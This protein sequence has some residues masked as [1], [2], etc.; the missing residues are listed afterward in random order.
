MMLAKAHTEFWDKILKNQAGARKKMK[1][2]KIS[3]ALA[4][5]VTYAAA[6]YS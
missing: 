6:S 5:P 2:K 3:A 4:R 1:T